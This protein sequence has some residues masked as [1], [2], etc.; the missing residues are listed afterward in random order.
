MRPDI[1]ADKKCIHVKL[2]KEVHSALRA[3]LFKHSISMQDLFEECA[4]LV[5]TETVKGQ[6]IVEAIVNRKIKETIEGLKKKKDKSLGELDAD[7][8]YSM[9]NG[10]SDSK[11]A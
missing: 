8:L 4:R 3:K 6:N 7:T 10:D 5:A 2:S 1:F 11:E 9:I